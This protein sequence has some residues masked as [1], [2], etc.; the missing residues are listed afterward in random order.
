[1]PDEPLAVL[2]GFVSNRKF[3][4]YQSGIRREALGRLVSHGTLANLLLMRTLAQRGVTAYDFLR[5]SSFYKER[6]AT[7][8]N[9]LVGMEIWRAS[10]RAALHRVAQLAARAGIKARE[11][12]KKK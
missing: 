2:Y 10:P 7:H 1:L 11:L 3:D 9:G 4:F 12:A 5:G 8:K 6:L